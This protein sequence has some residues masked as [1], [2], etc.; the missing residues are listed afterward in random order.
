M[1]RAKKKGSECGTGKGQGCSEHVFKFASELPYVMSCCHIMH[2]CVVS[3]FVVA[4]C[5]FFVLSGVE[6][7][8]GC[9]HSSVGNRLPVPQAA[10]GARASAP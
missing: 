10:N 4:F 3:I 7:I 5:T 6:Q 8:L 1:S 9:C 2:Q